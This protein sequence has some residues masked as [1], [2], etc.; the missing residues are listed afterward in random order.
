MGGCVRVDPAQPDL[1]E[2][3]R[4]RLTLHANDLPRARGVGSA[5]ARV[6]SADRFLAPS[7]VP[8]LCRSIR[9]GQPADQQVHSHSR[10]NPVLGINPQ[11]ARR[12]HLQDQRRSTHWGHR[13]APQHE[14]QQ[15]PSTNNK[16]LSITPSLPA[17]PGQNRTVAS[18]RRPSIGSCPAG[19]STWMPT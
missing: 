5:C 2:H 1:R 11:H 13:Y 18:A 9:P 4:F 6:R 8:R 15:S 16:R 3:P 17:D 12:H 19:A 10:H 7:C 14:A